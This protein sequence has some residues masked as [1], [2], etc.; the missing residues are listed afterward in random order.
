MQTKSGTNDIDGE[1]YDYVQRG[2]WNKLD[3][4]AAPGAAKP[5]NH[6]YEYGGV[7]GFPIIRDTLFG[8]VS[9]DGIQNLG[10]TGLNRGTF[11]A[12]DLDPTKRLTL[13][14]DTAA[15]RA[16]QD[17]ISPTSRR[18]HRTIP[19][20]LLAPITVWSITST[21]RPTTRRASTGTPT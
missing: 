20:S 16:L 7:V 13:G 19:P 14:N 6:R 10:Q 17:M 15:N 12:S 9:G 11:L 3:Y 18:A 8:F 4:F 1:L 5:N 21:R 2:N